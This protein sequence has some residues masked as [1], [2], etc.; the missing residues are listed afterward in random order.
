MR[1]MQAQ[2][3]IG[4]KQQ[5]DFLKFACNG[6]DTDAP[7]RCIHRVFQ[8]KEIYNPEGDGD[9]IDRWGGYDLCSGAPNAQGP[10]DCY[11]ETKKTAGYSIGG[12]EITRLCVRAKNKM[13]ATCFKNKTKNWGSKTFMDDIDNGDRRL[14]DIILECGNMPPQ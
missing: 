1:N 8:E 13:P 5:A 7:V 3:M 4:S 14:T 9:S 12:Y 2:Y 11:K 10:I 6:A